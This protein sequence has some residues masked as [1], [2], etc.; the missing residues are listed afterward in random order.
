M[1]RLIK[2]DTVTVKSFI[3]LRNIS[4]SNKS[5]NYHNFGRNIKLHNIKQ[6]CNNIYNKK[7]FLSIKSTY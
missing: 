5:C 6:A 1:D 3:M 7:C 4:I 2:S